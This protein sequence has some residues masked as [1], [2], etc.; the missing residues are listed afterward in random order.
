MRCPS[1]PERIAAGRCCVC[2]TCFCDACLAPSELGEPICAACAPRL[3]RRLAEASPSRSGRLLL[4]PGLVVTLV[5]SIALTLLLLAP[6]DA[7]L[8]AD[9]S[10]AAWRAAWQALEE[11]GLALEL[12]RLR[13]GRYPG[14]LEDLVPADLATL[15]SDP[16]GRGGAALVY[17]ETIGRPASRLLYS[18]GPDR[19]DQRGA[20]FDPVDR[21]GDLLYPLP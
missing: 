5:L 12:F 19:I 21:R 16:F 18:L 10:E 4:V 9:D 14:R 6:R 2:G 20:P 17:G 7:P 8:P 11:T 15:P 13:E 3:A 1:H